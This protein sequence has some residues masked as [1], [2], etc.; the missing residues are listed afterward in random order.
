MAQTFTF[1]IWNLSYSLL[2]TWKYVYSL[3]FRSSCSCESLS[4]TLLKFNTC[5]F[6]PM[7]FSG[8]D[9]TEVLLKVALNIITLANVTVRCWCIRLYPFC[10]KV[11]KIIYHYSVCLSCL[12][13]LNIDQFRSVLCTCV[14]ILS[15]YKDTM[16]VFLQISSKL[17]LCTY[18]IFDNLNTYPVPYN[19]WSTHQLCLITSIDC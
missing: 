17:E 18:F 14:D 15:F 3:C 9:I 12:Y 7:V 5:R 2:C 8:Y 10:K 13:T 11:I 4:F 19:I 1:P 16:K 6:V